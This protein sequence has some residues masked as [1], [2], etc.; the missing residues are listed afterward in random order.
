MKK[1]LEQ[2]VKKLGIVCLVGTLAMTWAGCGASKA[3][4]DSAATISQPSEN[5]SSAE[6]G[7]GYYYAEDVVMEEADMELADGKTTESTERGNDNEV[8]AGTNR[9]LI[10]TVDM[11]VET[12]EFEKVMATI[13]EQVA[14]LGGYIENM[15]TY[16][17][18]TYS[19][20]RSSRNASLTLRIPKER[21]GDF[22]TTIS[23]IS[24]VVRRSENVEDVTLAY[25][26][27]ESRRNSLKIEQDRLLELLSKAESMD[28]IITIE[29]RLSDV[30]YELESMESRL[31]TY[32]NKVDYSTVYLYIDEVKELTPIVE[33][34]AWQ[35]I[36]GG[37]VES[38]QDIGDGF[39]ELTIWFVVHIPYMV[40]WAVVIVAG[41]LIIKGI[42]KRR[43]SRK[44][45]NKENEN[46]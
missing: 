4:Y 35:R 31:R 5:Y 18:S 21:L 2:L 45:K 8:V 25:V 26:D 33:E 43:R 28:D 17:G 1:R 7:G 40:I 3:S 34:T 20:Y 36:T 42:C 16:N 22:L 23:D 41:V 44:Q 29:D 37:F 24:N 30:R 27:T 9:K 10:K 32:D 13:E 46:Q 11:N 6:M 19:H 38:L 39:V 12:K 15:E 14:A